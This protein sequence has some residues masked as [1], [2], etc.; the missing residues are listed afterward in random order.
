[1]SLH[2]AGHV[3]AAGR[4]PSPPTP[5]HNFAVSR[6]PPSMTTPKRNDEPVTTAAAAVIHPL[7]VKLKF[8]GAFCGHQHAF[9][10]TLRDNVRYVVTAGGG[11]PLWDLDKGLG[12]PSD[13]TR[14]VFHFVGFKVEGRTIRGHVYEKDGVEDPDLQFILCRHP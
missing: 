14:K 13:L 7:L 2:S 1:R 9:Y 8:C 10:T 5:W 3:A 12:L 11:A 4:P 6:P